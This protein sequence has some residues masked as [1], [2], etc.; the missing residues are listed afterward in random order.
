MITQI[1]IGVQGKGQNHRT[2]YSAEHSEVDLYSEIENATMLIRKICTLTEKYFPI[3]EIFLKKLYEFHFKPKSKMSLI[4]ITTLL[5]RLFTTIKITR[6]TEYL[7]RIVEFY[8]H[9]A[10]SIPMQSELLNS[11]AQIS[12][13]CLQNL[14]SKNQSEELKMIT[15]NY[16]SSL[17]Q[18]NL[19]KQ[20]Q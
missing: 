20:E 13:W 4:E 10:Q 14:I 16:I 6:K 5:E 15:K 11:Y 1:Q 8:F 3:V 18:Q 2:T 12:L 17:D 19:K 7:G 9:I